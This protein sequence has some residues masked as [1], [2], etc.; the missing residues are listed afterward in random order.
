MSIT[1]QQPPAATPPHRRPL[2]RR[3]MVSR[4]VALAVALLVGSATL[5]YVQALTYPGEASWQDRSVGW[6]REHGG[7]GLVNVLENWWY[8]RNAPSGAAPDPGS[9]PAPAGARVAPAPVAAGSAPPA[10]PLLA[11]TAALPGEAQW[12]PGARGV[13]GPALYTGW[14]RPD[15]AYPSRPVGV[16]WFDRSAT[17][18]HLVAG[19]RQ[20]VAGGSAAA[21]QVPAELRG[22]LVAVFNSG[23]K[24]ADINGGY[25]A[26]GQEVVP[27]RPG[28][29]SLVVDA[30]GRVSVGE[31]GR[32]A[33]MGPQVAAVRQN[34]DL[35]V[36][37]GSPVPGLR[38]NADGRWG[39]ARNQFQF[40]WRSG[41]GTDAA[42]DL[43]YLAGDQLTLA[44]LADA[45]VAAGVQRGMELDIHTGNA[46]LTS[47]DPA[48][49]DLA[50]SGTR[51]LPYMN[52]RLNRFLVPDQ[53]D[54]VAVTLR[55]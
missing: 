19:T 49:P 35:V 50:A 11:G 27:L 20:P 44:G 14:F 36:D 17:T 34:L 28:A 2:L 29:A 38:D 5:S 23:W 46:V 25:Y 52:Q 24:M 39:S 37:A 47:F 10:L 32:D 45:M 1:D 12:R 31:W 22:S 16:A 9:V 3:R 30:G 53:R 21:A 55:R 43:V 6:V 33:T 40:T 7:G 8:A 18:A 13:G 48:A 26:G 42:G 15:P 54:F 51:L 4:V 41:I